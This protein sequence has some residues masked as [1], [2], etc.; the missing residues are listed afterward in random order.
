MTTIPSDPLTED[1][2]TSAPDEELRRKAELFDLVTANISDVICRHDP[3]GRLL[4][5]S[6]AYERVFGHPFNERRGQRPDSIVY[7][8]DIPLAEEAI[9]AL[10]H[11]TDETT[12]EV[13]IVRKSGALTWL[14]ARCRA[15]R[16]AATGELREIV[17][18][19]RDVSERHLHQ[20]HMRAQDDRLR[21][22]AAAFPGAIYQFHQDPTGRQSV[23]YLGGQGHAIFGRP[24]E[25]VYGNMET[26]FSLVHPEDLPGLKAS[27]MNSAASLTPW[28]HIYRVFHKDGSIRWVRGTSLPEPRSADG[29]VTWNGV[30]FDITDLRESEEALRHQHEILRGIFDNLP[31]IVLT[32]ADGGIPQYANPECGRVLGYSLADLR[33]GSI[34]ETLFPNAE[35]RG[36]VADWLAHRPRTWSQFPVMCR[37]GGVRSINWYYLPTSAASGI[38]FGLDV[39]ESARHHEEM[40]RL[41]EQLFELQKFESLGVLAGGIAHD[42][43]NMLVGILGAAALARA[44][45]DGDN[46]AADLLETIETSS[47]QAAGVARQMLAYSGRTPQVAEMV[48]L[49]EV[50]GGMREFL[51]A[52][53][54]KNT[55][56]VYELASDVPRIRADASQI[57]RVLLNL[58]LNA[59]ESLRGEAG[60]VCIRVI[61]REVTREYLRGAYLG[62]E[63][64]PGTYCVLEVED[65]GCG[66]EPEILKRVVEPFYSTRAPGRGLGLSASLGIVRAHKGFLRADSE[67]GK[68]T[69]M[70]AGFPPSSSDSSGS[71][72]RAPATAGSGRALSVLI[73][74]DEAMVRSLLVRMLKRLGHSADAV[75][76]GED[77]IDRLRADAKRY[78]IVLLDLT[79][80]GMSGTQVLAEIRRFA[81]EL[82]VVLVSGYQ[83]I[84]AG[85]EAEQLISGFLPK[86]FTPDDVARVLAEALG[87]VGEA[88]A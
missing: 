37:G 27:I 9:L 40:A 24:L 68:G 14:E 21:Q 7:E 66:M 82:P 76:R 20:V 74:D 59:A 64:P 71:M 23:T 43:N 75:P 41:Q 33:T 79:M 47:R 25:E 39:T 12:L 56:L 3:D 26:A 85:S 84:D 17:V 60:R 32:C 35:V 15:V 65:T 57:G 4:Y 18:V 8:P 69:C 28:N 6:A 87:P 88:P 80:P 54:S 70:T 77:A 42:F 55:E 62:K 13:R 16:D 44:E 34:R 19:Y 72:K 81:P 45:I 58:V 10:Q 38:Y 67:P 1:P 52:S 48:S 11:D 49:A 36:A 86:P 78:D 63:T 61:E 29:S 50:A 30:L 73:V 5:A 53:V 83:S 22:I 2:D 46:P 51:A 31:L